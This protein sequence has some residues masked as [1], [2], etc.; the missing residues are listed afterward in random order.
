MDIN[1]EGLTK[2]NLAIEKSKPNSDKC[3]RILNS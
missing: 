1:K 2:C 3:L